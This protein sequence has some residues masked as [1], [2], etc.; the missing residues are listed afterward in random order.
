MEKTTRPKEVI[1]IIK[2]LTPEQRRRI[3]AEIADA[4][5]QYKRSQFKL[6]RGGKRATA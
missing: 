3:E 5:A 4:F 1:Q 2:R 6:I